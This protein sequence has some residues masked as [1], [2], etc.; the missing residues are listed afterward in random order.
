MSHG[1]ENHLEEAEHVSH[2]SHDP[3]D[4]RVAI[5][6]VLIAAVLAAVR[7]LGHRAHTESLL[8]QTQSDVQH[9]Q[10]SDQ[11]NFFQAKKMR[12]Q[13]REANADLLAAM[14]KK[15]NPE[16]KSWL[17]MASRYQTESEDVKKEAEAYVEEAKK[18]QHESEH[19]HHRSDRY[20]LGEMCVELALV[21][22]SVAILIR[23]SFFWYAGIASA[24]IG[25]ITAISGL[26]I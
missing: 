21:L 18:L 16:V 26:L 19:M 24:L 1:E 10:A 15:D 8:L 12:Q 13:I 7:L 6:M 23:R 20:D 25:F 14:T 11:W 5:T 9:T 4:R 3:F 22:C 17:D 2:A